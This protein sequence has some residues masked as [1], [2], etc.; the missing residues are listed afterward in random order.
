MLVLGIADKN[1]LACFALLRDGD[2]VRSSNDPAEA[3]ADIGF[4]DIDAIAYYQ[5]P[6]L[7]LERALET[8]LSFAPSSLHA[9]RRDIPRLIAQTVY[10]KRTLVSKISALYPHIDKKFIA[11][12]FL[13]SDQTSSLCAQAFYPSPYEEAAVLCLDD[14]GEWSGTAVAL[15]QGSNLTIER[16]ISYPHSLGLFMEVFA[17][18]L[19]IARADL[20]VLAKQGEATY[21]RML[22][23]SVIDIKQ[24]GSFLLNQFYFDY[25]AG[26]AWTN[27]ALHDLLGGLPRTPEEP[28]TQ[29]HHNIAASI[30]AIVAEI[31][32]R[33]IH[34]IARDFRGIHTLCVTGAVSHEAIVQE[35]I[36]RDHPFDHVDIAQ[37]QGNPAWAGGAALMAYY[38]HY[39]N[40]RDVMFLQNLPTALRK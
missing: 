30:M 2:I 3:V 36:L 6:Y 19:G 17:A 13:F 38:T 14:S 29:K 26:G 39:K 16:E 21:A 27:A 5:K 35:R 22:A 11:A 33:M 9:F 24:D 8:H 25:A 7:A 32:A 4:E 23:R 28:L 18:Y 31:A 40:P 34:A 12:K 15:G 37:S 20:G 10:K 1:E